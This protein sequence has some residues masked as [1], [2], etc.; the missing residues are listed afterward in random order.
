VHPLELDPAA[1]ARWIEIFRDYEI[2]QPFAQLAR[3]AHRATE[4]ER[5][6]SALDRIAG[7]AAYTG[8]L[9]A[10]RSRGWRFEGDPFSLETMVKDVGPGL[11]AVLSFE[12]PIQTQSPEM[13][14]HTLESLRLSG[15]GAPTFSRLDPIVFS[16]IVGDV[17][18]LR[19]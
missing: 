8:R 11:R 17:E 10:L 12:P 6:A 18:T 3:P 7:V 16:E 15:E 5:A 14:E 1:L 4:A 19:G 9:F 13:T 2:V